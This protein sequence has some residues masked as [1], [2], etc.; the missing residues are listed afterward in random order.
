MSSRFWLR[1]TVIGLA[2]AAIAFYPGSRSAS[3]DPGPPRVFGLSAPGS[4]AADVHLAV[5]ESTNVGRTA[6]VINLYA[7][8]QWKTPL[9]TRTLE[10]IAAAGA[11]PEIT[12]EPWDPRA[13]VG[14]PRYALSR[15][16][17]GDFD[18]YIR[19]WAHDAAAYRGNL[20][21]RFAHEM[22]GAWYPWSVS[23]NHGDPATYVAAYR[24]IHRIFAEAGA[25]NVTWVW[26]PNIIMAG[27][28]DALTASF[29]GADVVDVVGVDGYASP[30]AS[31]DTGLSVPEYLFGPT[32]DAVHAVASGIPVWINETGIRGSSGNPGNWIQ[33]LFEYLH[34]TPVVAVLWFSASADPGA[35]VSLSADPA[36]RSAA[37]RA[38]SAWW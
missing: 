27:N 10:A 31:S 6:G 1:A 35:L 32:L 21:L 15:I 23:A 24:H 7:A 5:Q 30:A 4:T 12:W 11:L 3:P 22:N 29:P 13:G 36:V 17:A 26:S 20:A 28:V 19:G 9:P 37:R 8:W 38:L 33:S 2:M 18:D 16:V 25:A 14:Q 34:G